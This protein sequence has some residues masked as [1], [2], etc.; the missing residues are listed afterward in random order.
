[1]AE[2]SDSFLQRKVLRLSLSAVRVDGHLAD[3]ETVVLQAARHQ[4]QLV[5]GEQPS[6]AKLAHCQAA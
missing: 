1:M 4:W 5:D 6:A 3:S 2:I